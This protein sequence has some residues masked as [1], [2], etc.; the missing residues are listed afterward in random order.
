MIATELGSISPAMLRLFRWRCPVF[1]SNRSGHRR[2]DPFRAP[3]G[4]DSGLPE[5]DQPLQVVAG[6]R[7]RHRKVCPRLTDGAQQFATHLL[8]GGKYMLDPGARF[9]DAQITPL[10]ALG[11]R[12]VTLAL[13][14]D[15]I[16][17]ALLFEPGFTRLR[18]VAPAGIDVPTRVARIEDVVE[19]NRLGF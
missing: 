2:F 6:N 7:H 4:L 19:V 15:L 5:V 10:P 9:G 17:K 3:E 11:Q 1:A 14:L 12:L 18:R 16:A 8:D 13:S